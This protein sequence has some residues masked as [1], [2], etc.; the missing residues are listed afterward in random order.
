MDAKDL[1][2]LRA[3]EFAKSFES[4]RTLEWQVIFQLYAGYTL[5]GGTYS[6]L[7]S[8]GN[9]GHKSVFSWMIIGAIILLCVSVLYLNFQIQK[10]QH[11][12]RTMQN[13]YLSKLHEILKVQRL[14]MQLGIVTPQHQKW[15]A[16]FIQTLLS[17]AFAI[18][19]ITFVL[20]TM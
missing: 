16:F 8:N 2:Q 6:Y 5:L 1:Y 12:A 3:E 11:H 14:E 7:I 10:R 13:A 19:L 18:G 20:L 4:L 17:V 9:I 15:Y